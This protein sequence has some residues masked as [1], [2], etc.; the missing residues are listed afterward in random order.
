VSS[1]SLLTPL[2]RDALL[3]LLAIGLLATPLW[4]P[5]D[6]FGDETH[7]YDRRGVVID[8]RYGITYAGDAAREPVG[9]VSDDIACSSALYRQPRACAFEELLVGNET[10]PTERYTTGAT[11]QITPGQYRYVQL[12]GSVYATT[13][14]VNESATAHGGLHRVELALDTAS[15]PDV[16]ERVSLDATGE[17][18]GVSETV[19]EVAREGSV[20]VHDELEVPQTPIQLDNGRYYRVYQNG[21]RPPQA[22]KQL[23]AILFEAFGVVAG[24]FVVSRLARSFEVSYVGDER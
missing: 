22:S 10:V 24:L 20:T 11:P 21:Q 23:F 6:D 19:A 14:V 17:H 2:R 8:D 12:N 5:L 15:A 13:Y 9:P 3:V 18:S 16:L 1:R 4:A 7:T